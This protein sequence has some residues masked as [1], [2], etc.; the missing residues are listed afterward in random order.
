[1]LKIGFDIDGTIT[2]PD[3]LIP[4]IQNKYNK[5]FKYEDLI[6]YEVNKVLGIS[7]E[8][9]LEFFKDN[10]DGI[11]LNP[12]MMEGSV[13]LINKLIKDGNEVHILTARHETTKKDTLIWLKREGILVE[14]SNIHFLGSHNKEKLIKDLD[15]DVYIDD[16]METLLEVNKL[17]DGNC[18]TVVIDAPY[19]RFYQESDVVRVSNYEELNM[20]L[21]H[22][23]N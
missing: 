8:D 17:M 18:K 12:N 15:L 10:H 4:L 19:N 9:M 3:N 21:T 23:E 2:T 13:N 20:Y 16:R 14:D 11:I 6:E 7:R 22:L 1:M 5:D